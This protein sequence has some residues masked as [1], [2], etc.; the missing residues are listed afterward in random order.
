MDSENEVSA[1]DS[2]EDNEAVAPD[3]LVNVNE[4]IK[5][6]SNGS[7]AV[8]DDLL[9]ENAKGK[10]I[11]VLD[12][13]DSPPMSTKSAPLLGTTMKGYGLKK[14]RRIRR[15]VNR[16][17]GSD[18]D[19]SKILK[20]GLSNSAV[21]PI[22]TMHFSAEVKQKSE[23]S[24]SSTNAMVRSPGAVV[25]GF[26]MLGDPGKAVGPTFTARSDSENSEDR[27]S[28]SSTAGSA[29]K[30]RYE[31]PA[32][33]GH[34]RNRLRSLSGKNLGNSVQR[35]QQGKVQVETSKKPR[36]ES[37]KIE[38]ENSH[39]SME[40][41]SRS[42]NFVFLQGSNLV[43]SNG[44]QSGMSMNYD[45]ENSDEAQGCED[46]FSEE[47]QTAYGRKDV[48]EFENASQDDLGADS[49]WEA[50][51]GKSE[52]LGSSSDQDPLVESI[53]SLQSVQEAL[54]RGRCACRHC[55]FLQLLS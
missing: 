50:K 22:K 38:K 42:S 25:D 13:M 44:R 4:T 33:G 11:E 52:N 41:D 35:S 15:E 30:M 55:Q 6:E 39:S 1:F 5:V 53:L 28:K 8:V 26:V 10:G 12:S 32:V 47:L 34:A 17:G 18:V 3:K 7:C 37:V 23:G 46:Q 2:V 14:W 9:L 36:G 21:K 51:E 16:H 19:I 43:T 40:S 27:S 49:S 54:E 48:G 24:V 29:P 45:G 31:K 20:R